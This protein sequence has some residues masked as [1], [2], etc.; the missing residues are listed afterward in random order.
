MALLRWPATLPVSLAL[1]VERIDRNIPFEADD[2]S[3]Y[4][5]SQW[6]APKWRYTLKFEAVRADTPAP[7]PF[8]AYSEVGVILHFVDEARGSWGKFEYVEPI[9]GQVVTVKFEKDSLKLSRDSTG[10][11]WAGE[12]SFITTR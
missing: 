4:V 2:G 5:T 3:E 8:E 12:F 7:S 9:G 10:L 11:W 1:P 6:T